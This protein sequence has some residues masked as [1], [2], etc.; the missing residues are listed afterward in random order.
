[1][2]SSYCNE[3]VDNKYIKHTT[4][5]YTPTSYTKMITSVSLDFKRNLEF[6]ILKRSLYFQ[7]QVYY[8]IKF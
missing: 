4:T 8:I 7:F 3:I 1:M 5:A 6:L 2:Y